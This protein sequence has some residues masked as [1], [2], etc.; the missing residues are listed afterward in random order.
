M[1]RKPWLLAAFALIS[2]SLS[3]QT[4]EEIVSKYVA[5]RGGEDKIKAVKT[6]RITGTISFGADADGPFVVE[7]RRPLKMHME[8]TLNGQTMIRTY[9]GKS[10]GWIYNP[11]SPK[12]EVQAMTAN[13]LKSIFDEADFDGPFVDYKAKGNQIEFVDKG[14][15]QGKPA[16]KLKLTNKNNDV[17]YFYFDADTYLILKWEGARKLADHDVAWE[18]IFH[19]FRD[20]EGVKYPFLIES[21]APGT[22]QTQR[23][24]A[25]KIEVNIP[26]DD[27][28]FL[29]PQL[30]A[31]PAPAGAPKSE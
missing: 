11:F 13:D 2:T 15:V 10:S 4:A 6:E 18:S 3:A 31:P 24:T 25:E 9:D 26:I 28:H 14:A 29:K 19:D 1:M 27:S 12:P 8:I 17:S 7:R 5:A 30:P 20:V 22:D 16:Y 23:I 21:D